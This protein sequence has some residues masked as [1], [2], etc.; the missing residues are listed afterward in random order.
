MNVIDKYQLFNKEEC[1]IYNVFVTNHKWQIVMS[2]YWRGKNVISM[3]GS[4]YN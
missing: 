4:N 3:I 1:Y 2:C